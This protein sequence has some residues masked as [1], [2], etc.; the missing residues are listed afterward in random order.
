MK[1]LKVEINDIRI[2]HQSNMME[3]ELN[4]TPAQRS[5]RIHYDLS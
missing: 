4:T 3:L 1:D 5:D 2:D